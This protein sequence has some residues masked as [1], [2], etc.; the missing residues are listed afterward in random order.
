MPRG[1]SGGLIT[2]LDK[3]AGRHFWFGFRSYKFKPTRLEFLILEKQFRPKHLTLSH[4]LHILTMNGTRETAPHASAA[5]SEWVTLQKRRHS[6]EH[7]SVN[8]RDLTIADVLAVS[9]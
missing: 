3:A 2:G 8:G 4:T 9:L 6:G 7:V 1:E 5:Y